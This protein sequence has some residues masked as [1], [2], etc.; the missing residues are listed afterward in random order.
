MSKQRNE[1]GDPAAILADYDFSK[2][3]GAG[4]DTG[5]VTTEGWPNG[6]DKSEFN[7]SGL[8]IVPKWINSHFVEPT[9]KNIKQFSKT[10]ESYVEAT[11]RINVLKA[12]QDK[13]KK[14]HLKKSERVCIAIL[15]YEDTKDLGDL[16][17]K[18]PISRESLR[19]AKYAFAKIIEVQSKSI[20][21]GQLNNEIERYMNS[22]SRA[23]AEGMK[24]ENDKETENGEDEKMIEQNNDNTITIKIKLNKETAKDVVLNNELPNDVLDQISNSILESVGL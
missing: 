23:V 17:N 19:R 3:D 20:T 5:K 8:D 16:Q 13:L 15:S 6:I 7:E 24:N 4:K 1:G 11:V 9:Q 2:S 12:S 14:E 21:K 18:Y 22:N 10:I